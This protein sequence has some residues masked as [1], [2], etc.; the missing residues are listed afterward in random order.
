[1]LL[2]NNTLIIIEIKINWT[3]YNSV[4][5]HMQSLV[6]LPPDDTILSA[7]N[8]GHIRSVSIS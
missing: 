4:S 7:V 6:A 2:D 5:V 8:F 3:H 1:M